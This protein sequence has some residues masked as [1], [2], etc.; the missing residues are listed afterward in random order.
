MYSKIPTTISTSLLQSEK[1]YNKD[2]LKRETLEFSFMWLKKSLKLKKEFH[3]APRR[4]HLFLSLRS[5]ATNFICNVPSLSLDRRLQENSEEG[6]CPLFAHS[7]IN[8]SL[9]CALLLPTPAWRAGANKRGIQGQKT[10]VNKTP[11]WKL[12]LC[13]VHSVSC[14]FPFLNDNSHSSWT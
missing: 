3:L 13:W 12:C 9:S 6:R 4:F 5:N 1:Q 7:L 14:G 11:K 10:V 2:F 8:F